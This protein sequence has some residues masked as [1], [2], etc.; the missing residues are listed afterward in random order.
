MEKIN[1]STALEISK[2]EIKKLGVEWM[3][4]I[5][6]DIP[7]YIS[8]EKLIR[9]ELDIFRLARSK[10]FEEIEKWIDLAKQYFRHSV[11]TIE[12]N[13]ILNN[14]KT[15]ENHK[16]PL[17]YAV[18]NRKN[19]KS[20]SVEKKKV[21]L[22]SI[23]YLNENVLNRIEELS[24][25]NFSTFLETLPKTF[26]GIGNDIISDITCDI[27]EDEFK[28]YTH[29]ILTNEKISRNKYNNFLH[30]DIKSRMKIIKYNK[31]ETYLVPSNILHDL[32]MDV[33]YSHIK[34][35]GSNVNSLKGLFTEKIAEKG[36]IKYQFNY[37]FFI[38]NIDTFTKVKKF[39][40]FANISTNSSEYDM[41]KFNEF[42]TLFNSTG[43]NEFVNLLQL[44][45]T[46]KTDYIILDHEC[47]NNFKL[48]QVYL[49][50]KIDKYIHFK[51]EI[52]KEK[53]AIHKPIMN[54][55]AINNPIELQMFLRSFIDAKTHDCY[56]FIIQQLEND[57]IK[58]LFNAFRDDK[59][60]IIVINY[61]YISDKENTDGFVPK[62][63]FLYSDADITKSF[64]LTSEQYWKYYQIKKEIKK[65]MKKFRS[66]NGYTI[67][68]ALKKLEILK[69]QRTELLDIIYYYEP[70]SEEKYEEK[71][72]AE[73]EEMIDKNGWK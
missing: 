29:D 48:N 50:D 14:W 65:Y 40:E 13:K 36:I 6:T 32:N 63:I 59:L 21:F 17:G 38:D 11:D 51:Y 49:Q 22:R 7:K 30:Y 64:S 53:S 44:F 42:H 55:Y 31:T 58:K 12:G 33:N 16:F 9:N 68:T 71:L 25:I 66:N 35:F 24:D 57:D 34:Q 5:T 39:R 60:K 72:N 10:Y 56:V 19:G 43:F 73:L 18:T 41:N 26:E 54:V 67:E 1:L 61:G 46:D 62:K 69:K 70:D 3:D 15:K 37:D 23:H 52:Y 27:F 4:D 45:L 8:I 2:D 20:M 28:K 47:K